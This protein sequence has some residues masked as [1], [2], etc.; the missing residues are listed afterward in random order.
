MTKQKTEK[1]MLTEQVVQLPQGVS[2]S[3]Q[4]GILTVTGPAG[5]N[6]KKLFIPSLNIKVEGDTIVIKPLKNTKNEKKLLFTFRAHVKNL[7]LGVENAFVYKLKICSGHFPMSVSING[8]EFTI[9]NFIGEKVPRTVKILEDAKVVI[10]GDLIIVEST[11][12]ESAGQMAARIEKM[13]RRPGF[14]TRIFQDGIYIVEKAG[15][16]L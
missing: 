8:N 10:N 11:N 6:K 7:V 13:T 2:A 12:K 9:K 4:D 16:V 1:V 5:S 3:Y 15:K 14:D